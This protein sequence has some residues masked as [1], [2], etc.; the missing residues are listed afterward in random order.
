M[1]LAATVFR[2]ILKGY[3]SSSFRDAAET[4]FLTVS[5][6]VDEYGLVHEVCGCPDFICQGTSAE[7]QASFIMADAWREKLSDP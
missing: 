2:G 5:E 7:A 1:M 6:K 3:V 4:A